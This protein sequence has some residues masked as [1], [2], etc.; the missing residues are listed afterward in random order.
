MQ[1][2]ENC[3]LTDLPITGAYFS[4]QLTLKKLS[5]SCPDPTET[6]WNTTAVEFLFLVLGFVEE[7]VA[8]SINGCLCDSSCGMFLTFQSFS[9]RVLPPAANK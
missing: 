7:S 3:L 2:L 9:L 6:K 8:K 1:H 5:C 4:F